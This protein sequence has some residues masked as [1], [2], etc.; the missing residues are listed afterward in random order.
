ML[1]TRIRSCKRFH[2][3]SS[4]QVHLSEQ[5]LQSLHALVFRNVA[6]FSTCT[7]LYSQKSS[8]RKRR[9][10][11]SSNMMQASEKR[12]L[13]EILGVKRDASKDEIKKA[14]YKLAKKHHPD[15]N[16]DDPN[17]AQ[18][19]T[20]VQNAYEVLSDDAKRSTYDNFGHEGMENMQN[21]GNPGGSREEYMAAEEIFEKFFGR[22]MGGRG[23]MGRGG[24]RGSRNGGRGEDVSAPLKLSFMEAVQGVVRGVTARVDQ[25][26]EECNGTGSADKSKPTTCP[27]C[28]GTGE[29]TTQQGFFAVT[30]PCRK[31]SGEGTLL[32]NP[33]KSCSGNGVV[34]KLKTVNVVVP[35]GIDDGMN[36]RLQGEGGAGP[37]GG[38]PGNFYVKII[39]EPDAFFKREDADIHVHVP[40]SVA[41]ATLGTTISV[42]TVRG[43]VELKIPAGTQPGD[44][45][46]LRG[47]GI[48]QLEGG[49]TGH[50]YVH[51]NVV[52]PKSINSV[53]KE[54]YQKLA[55]E[56]GISS[57]ASTKSFLQET[58]DRIKRALGNK[59]D[60]KT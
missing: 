59:D 37:R 14:Y 31:C 5:R 39:V 17:A 51:I 15:T 30:M 8:C 57:T 34:G 40:I 47:R 10:F 33:C 43:E 54:L 25:S 1:C 38:P 44:K 56:E 29:E 35:P 32:K 20:D 45:L 2:H 52:I 21:G 4:A 49:S 53:Q 16:K 60:K 7:P 13:Y 55:E 9:F 3:V 48:K 58:I 50:Q 6:S 26:C 42:P 23:G 24:M 41:Q 11:H 27:T 19:F 46:L 18:K 22:S 36:L 12:D 28:R